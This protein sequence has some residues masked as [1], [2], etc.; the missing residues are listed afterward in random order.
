MTQ[1]DEGYIEEELLRK[2]L[3]SKCLSFTYERKHILREVLEFS[4]TLKHFSINRLYINLLEKR[5]RISK[6]TL[7]RTIK[8]L[9]DT[10]IVKKPI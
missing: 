4:K 6:S 2:F 3:R 1:R 10:R 8:L 5:D 7:Y 9:E